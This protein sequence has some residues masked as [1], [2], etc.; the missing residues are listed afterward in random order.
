MRTLTTVQTDGPVR[1]IR[2]YYGRSRGTGVSAY[3]DGFVIMRDAGPEVTVCRGQLTK[4]IAALE[5]YDL[6]SDV[7]SGIIPGTQYNKIHTMYFESPQYNT[8]NNISK[9]TQFS[10]LFSS[11][12]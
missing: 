7:G 2:K 3:C 12:I 10:R 11:P 8:S 1:A 6:A 5:F 9:I 4:V